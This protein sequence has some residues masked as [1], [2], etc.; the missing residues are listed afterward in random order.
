MTVQNTL[1]TPLAGVIQSKSKK[2]YGYT[3]PN[4]SRTKRLLVLAPAHYDAT[5]F[6]R[7]CGPFL[8]M[9]M[10]DWKIT[11]ARRDDEIDWSHIVENDVIFMQRPYLA[12]HRQVA[13]ITVSLGRALWVDYDDHVLG[14]P[15]S[16]PACMT[17]RNPDV[18]N[19]IKK[20][21][22][23]AHVIT[24]STYALKRELLKITPDRGNIFVIPNAWNDYIHKWNKKPF[25]LH[26]RI[27]WRGSATHNEDIEEHLEA[28]AAVHQRIPDWEWCFVGQPS[29]RI[30]NVLPQDKVTVV[31][32]LHL[33][34]YF[35]FMRVMEASLAIVPLANSVF[36]ECKSNIAWQEATCAGAAVVAPQWDEWQMGGITHYGFNHGKSFADACME[37]VENLEMNYNLSWEVLSQERR[38]S[39]INAHRL[40]IMEALS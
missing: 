11:M 14:I 23:I 9:R 36:N 1:K 4:T 20:V 15:F 34:K 39:K 6:Y 18:I 2:I 21:L 24:V 35:N 29:F 16:N 40:R 28:I 32:T 37:A 33:V 26:K 27:F 17:Y 30:M 13:E 3:A 12:E 25:Q 38:L 7:A 22:E 5:S 19:S 31:P 10:H 8:S